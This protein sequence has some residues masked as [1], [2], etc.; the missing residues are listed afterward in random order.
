[1]TAE[2]E[3]AGTYV[4]NSNDGERLWRVCSQTLLL[5]WL[6]RGDVVHLGVAAPEA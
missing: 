6:W 4:M 3:A 2:E 1:V 5:L